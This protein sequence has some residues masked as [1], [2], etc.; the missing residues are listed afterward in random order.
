MQRQQTWP[1]WTC[2]LACLNEDSCRKEVCREGL[3]LFAFRMT[4]RPP[5]SWAEVQGRALGFSKRVNKILRDCLFQQNRRTCRECLN[6]RPRCREV[7]G[8][9]QTSEIHVNSSDPHRLGFEH[10]FKTRLLLTKGTIVKYAL[11]IAFERNKFDHESSKLDRTG[12]NNNNNWAHSVKSSGQ[13]RLK[14][15]ARVSLGSEVI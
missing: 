13:P 9:L 14:Y 7:A 2:D 11:S 1:H 10:L 12:R 6:P 3:T 5:A 8:E 15:R 4:S